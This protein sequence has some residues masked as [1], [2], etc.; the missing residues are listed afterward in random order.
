MEQ[1]MIGTVC[2][3]IGFVIGGI[4]GAV[5]V[6]LCVAVK[7]VRVVQQEM[8]NPCDGC[9]GASFGDCDRCLKNDERG[10]Q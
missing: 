10:E 5:V 7:N 6:A 9:F 8:D 2:F 4:A 3:C 1:V